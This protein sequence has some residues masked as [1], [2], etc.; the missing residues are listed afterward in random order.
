MGF[1]FS[2][3]PPSPESQARL[4]PRREILSWAAQRR[5]QAGGLRAALRLAQAEPTVAD[6][7]RF[8]DLLLLWLGA[9]FV[10]VGLIFFIA[11]NWQAMGRYAKFGLVEVALLAAVACSWKL[12][13]ERLSGKAA[14]C[15]ASLLVGAL[16]ALIGQTYQTGADPWQL[17]AGWALLILPWV[18]IGRF[19]ALLL[20][21]VGLVNLSLLLYLQTFP[22]AFGFIGLLF[23]TQTILWSLFV[24]NTL[25]LC[26]WELAA[27]SRVSW[28]S[29]RWPLRVLAVASG[30]LITWLAVWAI[31]EFHSV[32]L[33]G[34]LVDLAWLIAVYVVYRRWARDVFV[35]AGGVLSA[36]I[37]VTAGLA[38]LLIDHGDA[39]GLLV[40]GLVTIGMSAAGGWWL[41]EIA[42]EE[43]S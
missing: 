8:L 19:A 41:K 21:W 26:L 9:I 7:R 38:R 27:Q 29:E 23:T 5:I 34:L 10:A 32:G 18:I 14:L 13:L 33:A 42:R 6:W 22:R 31:F 39:G 25:I 37:V 43:R 40:I 12:G 4:N 11:Y 36:I 30:G 20:S 15:A 28:L 2:V 16:L 17:F 1:E 35:L 24:L 3:E